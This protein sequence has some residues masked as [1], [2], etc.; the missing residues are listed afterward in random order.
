M[1]VIVKQICASGLALFYGTWCAPGAQAYSFG[2]IVP[3]VRQPAAIS[4][5]SACPTR[6]HRLTATGSIAVRWSTALNTSPVTILPQNPTATRRPTEIEQVIAQ[7][8]AVWT[9]GSGTTPV[10]STAAP[11]TRAASP[12]ALRPD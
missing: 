12:E 7:S 9:G 11:L 10:S 1:N 5:G 6:T 3:D 2:M 8:L 4:G